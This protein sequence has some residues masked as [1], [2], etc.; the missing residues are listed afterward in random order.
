MATES[1]ISPSG[2]EVWTVRKVLD[3]TTGHFQRHGCETPRL[4][5]EILLSHVRECKRIELYTRFDDLVTDEQ[6]EA[7]RELVRR[8]AQ[9]E[10]VAY[11]VGY[12]EFYGLEFEVCPDVLI[13]RPDT[14]TLVLES[15][16]FLKERGRSR[17][18]EI[19]PG[20]GCISV[21][22]AVS[23]PGL[24]ITAVDI[25]PGALAVAK[26]NA[27]RHKVGG[28][29]SFREGN[30]FSGLRNGTD[31][32]FDLIV[33]N[34]PYIGEAEVDQL[35]ADVR[36]FEPRVALVSGSDGLDLIREIAE[37]SVEWLK[38]GGALMIELAPEQADSTVE[39]L[40]QTG[41]YGTIEQV[42]DLSGAVR[43]VRCLREGAKTA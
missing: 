37:Q 30:A 11:L 28:S 42:N 4:D 18:L 22:L 16:D 36:R 2:P 12:R 5:A 40:N 1:T 29:I 23:Q 6:R 9:S 33:T 32:P 24:Q 34:P 14:E 15:L 41:K 7:M 38:P 26:R 25:S 21:S 8:R 27:D 39:L 3:W 13:P 19:G 20:S 31:E 43:V 10:P 17:V 35:M